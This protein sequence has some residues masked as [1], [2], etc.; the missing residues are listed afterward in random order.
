MRIF[1]LILIISLITACG[2]PTIDMTTASTLKSSLRTMTN[3]MSSDE[4]KRF[5]DNF[6]LV[7]SYYTILWSMTKNEEEIRISLYKKL[8][9]KSVKDIESMAK[10]IRKSANNS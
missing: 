1:H 2:G 4:S 9:G 3:E 7:I 8:H 5:K 6:N 10:E